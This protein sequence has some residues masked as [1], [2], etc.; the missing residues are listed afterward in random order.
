MQQILL[1]DFCAFLDT[2]SRND[3]KN[4][5]ADAFLKEAAVKMDDLAPFIYFR[6]E[7]YARNL[8][9]KSDKYELLI[10][11][12]LSEQRTPI[13]D[14]FGQRCWMWVFSGE[15]SFKNYEVPRADD[16]PLVPMG[17][18]ESVE[19]PSL[20]YIDDDI[21]VHSIANASKRP[22]LSLHLYAGPVPQCRVYNERTKVF[23]TVKLQYFTYLGNPIPIK[24][25]EARP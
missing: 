7:T 2:L 13:H 17:P 12:W 4:G 20:I 19:A 21:S 6:E 5:K 22:A 1:K 8:V 18:V 14:H 25:P 23:E 16:S 9:A 11:S 3:F 10:L 15:L 24:V